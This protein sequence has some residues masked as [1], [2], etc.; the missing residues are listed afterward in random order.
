[1]VYG[2]KPSTGCHLCRKRKIK[3][4]VTKAAPGAAT[5]PST[6]GHVQAIAQRY[7]PANNGQTPSDTGSLSDAS[8]R[9]SSAS[10]S[11]SS[12]DLISI[13]D[14]TWLQ[15]AICYFFDQFTISPDCEGIGHMDYLPP[16]YA[17]LDPRTREPSG[18]V[19]RLSAPP[20]MHQARQRFGKALRSLRE[21]LIS[22]TQ[23][24]KDE[25]FAAMLI[26]SLYEDISG[27]RNGLHSSHTA[28]FEY[29]M[30]LRG[31]GQ[32]EHQRGR[33][34]FNFAYVQMHVGILALGDKPRDNLDSVLEGLSNSDDPTERL[35]LTTS[36]MRHLYVSMQSAPNPPDQAAI[37]G[38][39]HSARDI[40]QEICAWGMSL[41]D[42]WLPLVVY[43]AQGEQLL[44]YH[45][46]VHGVTWL[47]YRALR[48]LLQRQIIGLNRTLLSVLAQ[49]SQ[50]SPPDDPPWSSLQVDESSLEGIIKEMTADACRSIPFCLSQVDYLGRPLGPNHHRKNIRAAQCFGLVWPLWYILTNGMPS[51][52]QAEQIISVL[53]HVGHSQG[54]HLALVL[55]RKVE[56]IE[57]LRR[58]M[59]GDLLIGLALG[60]S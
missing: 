19:F 15:R 24:A 16:L 3:N 60:S 58:R 57:D 4:S 14:A 2:G 28:G 20:L 51:P 7:I 29:L 30:K 5:A 32:L 55:A 31:Q 12:L 56:G 48:I 8:S 52:T 23:A 33:D 46:G 17:Q 53:H 38:W 49:K 25:T 34:M 9:M 40:D 54:I 10:S 47:Y 44:T 6:D 11:S 36:K 1:M 37:E 18:T 27:E 43:S 22:P 42:R 13:P 45:H 41:P 50:H 39:I 35:M 26:L 59:H 21:A